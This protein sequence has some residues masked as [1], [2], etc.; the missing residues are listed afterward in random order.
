MNES[1]IL[2]SGGAGYIGSHFIKELSTTTGFKVICADNLSTGHRWAA[3]DV[4]LEVVDI[5]SGH[6]DEIFSK[7]NFVAV[8]HFAAFSIV[9]ESV[10]YPTKYYENNVAGTAA[11]ISC[12]LR[13]GVDNFVFSS[14]ASIYGDANGASL[15][16]ED[17]ETAPVN[18]YGRSKLMCEWMLK[19]AKLERQSFRY[20]VMR[21]FNVAGAHSS[22]LIGE[23]HDPETHLIPK[24]A[25]AVLAKDTKFSVYGRDYPTADGTCVRDYI[26]V[27][28]LARAHVCAL[29]YLLAGGESELLNCGYGHGYSVLEVIRAMERV[30]GVQ[31]D[32]VWE[33]RREGDPA[34]LVA[35][36]DRLREVLGWQPGLDDID[37]I[38]K[39][40][41]QWERKMQQEN[42]GK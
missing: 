27:E 41:L 29:N 33:E 8:V 6:L 32:L 23:C 16:R 20:V 31:I 15:I 1:A 34:M 42:A 26:H 37:I 24:L 19:D 36:S 10:R 28:D 3:Q 12:C 25:K 22:G 39:S 9:S 30:S 4:I 7:Y 18:P 5:A 21:Y 38:C 35:N 40:A 14:T 2:V 13:H 11:L 17:A